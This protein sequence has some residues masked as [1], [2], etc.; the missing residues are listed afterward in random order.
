MSNSSDRRREK[1]AWPAPKSHD[2]RFA[3][4]DSLPGATAPAGLT[5]LVLVREQRVRRDPM[6]P[7]RL[8]LDRRP[9]AL[10]PQ[11]SFMIADVTPGWHRFEG[12]LDAPALV[13]D[14]HAG[15][16]L[17]LRMREMIDA[18]EC[19]ASLRRHSAHAPP[20]G[21]GHETGR[22]GPEVGRRRDGAP[23]PTPSPTRGRRTSVPNRWVKR[24]EDGEIP[25]RPAR[26]AGHRS[27]RAGAERPL[28]A[29]GN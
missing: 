1:V 10:L 2:K 4:A 27:R 25:P 17:L 12:V 29:G 11:V 14:C 20:G 9:L 28:R 6:P 22:E 8:Y 7:E 18:Q 26:G 23:L 19:G 15:E 5:R 13:I 16:V 24:I 21:D 3:F